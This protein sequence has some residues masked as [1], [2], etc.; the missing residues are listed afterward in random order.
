MRFSL[1]DRI[2]EL[3]PGRR[4]RAVK[5][6]SLAEEYLGDHFPRFPVLPGVLMLEALTESAAWL[7]RASEDFAHSIVVLKEAK[8]IRYGQFVEPGQLL[9]LTAEI[10]S[11]DERYT[12]CKAEG[13]M[14]DRLTVSGKIRLERRNLA[15]RDPELAR[16]DRSV[17]KD[18]RQLFGILWPL[19][20]RKNGDP[21]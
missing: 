12:E 16:V 10:V 11:Q 8:R 4:I 6:L 19:A 7:V 1:I 18:M 5:V 15:E 17:I 3:E 14:E 21:P 2:L 9:Y 13:R 20:G